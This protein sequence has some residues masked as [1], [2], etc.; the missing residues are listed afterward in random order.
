MIEQDVFI[1][2]YCKHEI[3]TVPRLGNKGKVKGETWQKGQQHRGRVLG[4]SLLA[5]SCW[6]PLSAAPSWCS[7]RLPRNTSTSSGR[8]LNLPLR[9]TKQAYKG[10]VQNRNQK[11]ST[12]SRQTSEDITSCQQPSRAEIVG[13]GRFRFPTGFFCLFHLVSSLSNISVISVF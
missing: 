12:S 4:K 6:G 3:L 1:F 2:P 8:E 5:R 11:M 13:Q 9:Q 7:P 10:N